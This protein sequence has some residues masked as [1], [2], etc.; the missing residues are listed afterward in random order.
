MIPRYVLRELSDLDI[1]NLK[2][3][4]I[5]VYALKEA[6]KRQGVPALDHHTMIGIAEELNDMMRAAQD[7]RRSASFD[8]ANATTR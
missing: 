5:T 1:D 4:R 6:F 7:S 3:G 2:C 8:K